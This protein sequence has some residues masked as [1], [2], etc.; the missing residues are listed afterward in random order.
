[1]TGAYFRRE[2]REKPNFLTQTCPEATR[3][4]HIYSLGGLQFHEI[5]E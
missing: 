5:S 1:M 3:M 2:L 4:L